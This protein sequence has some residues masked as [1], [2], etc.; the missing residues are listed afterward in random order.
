MNCNAQW[1]DDFHHSL[2]TLLTNE[3][4]GFYKDFGSLR[5]L[6]DAYSN[7][8]VY[9]GKYSKNRKKIF[10][11]GSAELNSKNFIVFL[12]NHDMT[13]NRAI[14]DRISTLTDHQSLKLAASAVLLSPFIPLI[15]NG[16][17]YGET[18]PF[19]YFVDHSD[20]SLIE[21]V[22]EGRKKEFSEFMALYEIPDPDAKIIFQKSKL[23]FD[24]QSEKNKEILALYKQLIAIRKKI[25]LTTRLPLDKIS[26]F[27][28][29]NN[30][31]SIR[32][33]INTIFYYL[34][35][36]FSSI[37]E[38]YIKPFTADF[39]TLFTTSLFE[40]S[41]NNVNLLSARSATLIQLH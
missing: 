14:G 28:H 19:F 32:Y 38:N 11:S 22:R 3:Q 10:G 15:F 18:N 7:G 35:L 8:Y 20:K 21:M 24:V 4:Y 12:Q 9:D 26:S 17:E 2:H 27:T 23:S 13:G 29:N 33:E 6:S 16:E 39:T 41:H 1:C 5:D 34:I 31:L 25:G 36:N 30:I 37:D 40:L